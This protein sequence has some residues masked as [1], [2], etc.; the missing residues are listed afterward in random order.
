MKKIKPITDR[1]RKMCLGKT[2]HKSILSAQ[3]HLYNLELY[4]K[5]P[6][7]LNYYKCHFCKQ[8]HCGNSNESI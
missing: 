2:K 8:Y 7:R 4:A 5:T 1:E 3:E 6:E